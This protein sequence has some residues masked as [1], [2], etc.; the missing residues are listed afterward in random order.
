METL[1]KPAEGQEYKDLLVTGTPIG[2]G[3]GGGAG[4]AAAATGT[5]ADSEGGGQPPIR[6][7]FS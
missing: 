7:Y 2:G 5:A 4:A 1:L 6:Y 3:A